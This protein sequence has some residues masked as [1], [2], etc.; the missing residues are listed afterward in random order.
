MLHRQSHDKP[1]EF[2]GN[3][4]L[5][6]KPAVRPKVANG[7][8]KRFLELALLVEL[9]EPNFVDVHVTRCT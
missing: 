7:I 6:R 9:I 3:F 8:E 1:V 5:T 2:L 4:D